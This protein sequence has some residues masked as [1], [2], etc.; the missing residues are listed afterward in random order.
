MEL[1]TKTDKELFCVFAVNIHVTVHWRS[2]HD[3]H[4][5]YYTRTEQE[6]KFSSVLF[7]FLLLQHS[8]VDTYTT[9]SPIHGVSHV[10]STTI[11]NNK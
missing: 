1:L 4:F 6:P 11:I 10:L 9:V 8:S 5:T 7:F 3:L 2:S